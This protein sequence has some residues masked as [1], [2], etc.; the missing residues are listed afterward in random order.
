MSPV[1][2]EELEHTADVGLRV[3]GADLAQLF[4]HAAEGMFSLIGSAWFDE[5]ETVT[6]RWEFARTDEREAL[7]QWL[8]TLLLE[9]ALRGFFPTAISLDLLPGRVV[10]SLRGGTFDPARHEF[11]TEIKAVTQHGLELRG[12]ARRGFEAEVIFDV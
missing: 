9:F 5:D 8:R 12:D 1:K 11:F 4:V 10:A 2:Y 7:Y 3:Y 6:R